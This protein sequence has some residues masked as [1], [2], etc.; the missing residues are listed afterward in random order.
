MKSMKVLQKHWLIS[1][2][3]VR[4]TALKRFNDIVTIT[5]FIVVL[6]VMAVPSMI[7]CVWSQLYVILAE[8]LNSYF[9]L[10]ENYYVAYWTFKIHS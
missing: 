9:F 5:V 10:T 4:H 1:F 7:H 8:R 6:A 3:I 2:Y